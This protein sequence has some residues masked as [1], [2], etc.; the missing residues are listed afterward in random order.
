MVIVMII[1]AVETTGD[2]FATGEIVK[3]ELDGD[4]VA[5]AIRADG[6]A[7]TIGGILNSFPYTC[8]AENVGLVRLTKVKSRYVV[9]TAGVFMMIIGVIPKIGAIVAAIPLPVLG[10]AGV[11]LFGTVAV[12]GIQ[13]LRRVDFHEESN[14]IILAT[15]LGFAIAPTVY[16]TITSGFNEGVR[17]IIS[18]GITLG[19]VAAILLNL[20]FNVW[21][22]RTTWCRG[23]CPHRR[24]WR[25]SRSTRSTRWIASNSSASSVVCSRSR[26]GWPSR[27]SRALPFTDVYDLRKSL[28]DAV[29]DAPA[30]RQLELIRSYPQLGT[31]FSDLTPANRLSVA[32]PGDGRP[33]PARQRRAPDAGQ[34]DPGVPGEVRPAGHRGSGEHEGNDHAHGQRPAAEQSDS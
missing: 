15:S 30:D 16:P 23:S 33:G 24:A 21:A 13:T 12:V 25:C 3:K 34:P 10:G 26:P 8:F 29:F 2:V 27:R 6:L 14:V 9:A 11:V 1:T 18:S 4:D 19:A 28:Q 32:R 17:T 22:A 20:L 5:R 7:T 31:V